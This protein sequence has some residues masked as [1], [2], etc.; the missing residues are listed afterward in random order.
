[1]NDSNKAQKLTF[2]GLLT[3]SKSVHLNGSKAHAIKPER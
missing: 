1:M 2:K 3:Q